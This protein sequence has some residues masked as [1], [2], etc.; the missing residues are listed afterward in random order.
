ML[1]LSF[2]VAIRKTI[3]DAI[4]FNVW[5]LCMWFYFDRKAFVWVITKTGQLELFG[6]I[7]GLTAAI[8]SWKGGFSGYINA[9]ILDVVSR[10]ENRSSPPYFS[11]SMDNIRQQALGA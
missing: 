1:K 6:G 5:Q 3:E 2:V 11:L 4:L 10:N 8:K 7:I 9:S